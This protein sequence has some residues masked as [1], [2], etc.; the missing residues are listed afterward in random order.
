MDKKITDHVVV[1][2]LPFKK[3]TPGTYMFEDQDQ[4]SIRSLYVRKAAFNGRKPKG[5][6]ITVTA[7]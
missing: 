6:I 3:E 4:P 7:R 1:V 2:E 5:V